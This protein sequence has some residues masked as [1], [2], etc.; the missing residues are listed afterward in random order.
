LCSPF[1][2]ARIRV[3]SVE[4]AGAA[5]AELGVDHIDMPATPDKV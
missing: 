2:H 4:T 5:L 1:A 3:F